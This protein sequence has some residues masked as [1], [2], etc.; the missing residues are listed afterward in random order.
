MDLGNIPGFSSS[1]DNQ[2]IFQGKNFEGEVPFDSKDTTESFDSILDEKVLFNQTS[3]GE[4]NL[5]QVTQEQPV[6]EIMDSNESES[7]TSKDETLISAPE[8]MALGLS[9]MAI[10]KNPLLDNLDKMSTSFFMQDNPIFK[11]GG[12]P[13]TQSYIK[14][15]Q[16][17]FVD[18]YIKSKAESLP[19]IDSLRPSLDQGLMSIDNGISELSENNLQGMTFLES[20]KLI[21]QI[22]LNQNQKNLSLINSQESSDTDFQESNPVL[23]AKFLTEVSEGEINTLGSD[24]NSQADDNKTEVQS[25]F[26]DLVSQLGDETK[27]DSSNEN[28]KKE[29]D[30]LILGE[31]L[32][33][34]KTDGNEK[35]ESS[36]QD[37]AFLNGGVKSFESKQSLGSLKNNS[38]NSINYEKIESASQILIEKGGGTARIQLS[39]EGLGTIDLK[40]KVNGNQVS[41]ELVT[42]NSDTKELFERSAQELQD[43]LNDQKLKL[44]SLKVTLTDQKLD[45]QMFNSKQQSA[46]APQF[47]LMRDLMQQSRQDSF[48]RQGQGFVEMDEIKNY[49][50]KQNV[51]DPI[52]SHEVTPRRFIQGDGR[53]HRLSLVG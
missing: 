32:D 6:L 46:E 47:S 49:G 50:R 14:S 1:I 37:I 38:E 10:I 33:L 4:E 25:R 20:K 15:Y 7:S 29:R 12:A 2:Q 26:S 41:I 21:P 22:D 8:L 3:G 51:V 18:P 52:K 24:E 23:A 42:S 5:E 11:G 30:P 43:I 17:F 35:D 44:D 27:G 36:F 16:D 34:K 19:G 31:S 28:L 39:P 45:S 9:P 40:L 13:Q 48:S 53:G